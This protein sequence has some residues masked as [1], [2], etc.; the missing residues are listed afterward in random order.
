MDS[1]RLERAVDCR[2]VGE[3]DA[4]N[5]AIEAID[6]LDPDIVITDLL[7]REG[8]GVDLVRR[9][10]ARHG[11][12]RPAIFVLT[13]YASPDYRETLSAAG[14]DACFDKR[15]EYGALIDKVRAVA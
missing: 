8:T 14:A 15:S 1:P 9:V 11:E 3:A 2:I 12:G 6:E 5:D 10:R 4:A 7:L 13:N